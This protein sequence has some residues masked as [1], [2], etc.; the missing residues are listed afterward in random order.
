MCPADNYAWI[1]GYWAWGNDGYFWVPGT[2]IMVPAVG[3]LWTPGYWEWSGAVY[4][5]HTGYWGPHVGFYGGI[6]YGYGYGGSGFEG[7]RWQGN[8]YYYNRAVTHVNVI[9]SNYSYDQAVIVN[10]TRI[11]YRGGPEGLRAM[12][13]EVE[14]SAEQERHLSPTAEQSRQH[15]SASQR[16]ALLFSANHGQ[17]PVAATSRPVDFSP[18]SVI[19]A[20]APGGD[21][22][23]ETRKAA[24]RTVVPPP[25]A[26]NDAPNPAASPEPRPSPAR[27]PA[28]EPNQGTG[29]ERKKDPPHPNGPYPYIPT[30]P[31]EP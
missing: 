15:Q 29:P 19:P 7:A 24:P 18:K 27:S 12:P 2:W 26:R 1:P 14:R 31:R 5:F 6:N 20:K 10:N 21:G 13:T 3:M 4:K 16:K 25:K 22:G 28:P 9:R 11:A 17:P 23:A 8:H 30:P